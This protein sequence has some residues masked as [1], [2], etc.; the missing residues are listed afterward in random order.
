MKYLVDA[1][2]IVSVNAVSER[3][4]ANVVAIELGDRTQYPITVHTPATGEQSVFVQ[5]ADEDPP[6]PPKKPVAGVSETKQR[7]RA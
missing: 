5:A 6:A 3:D 2:A 1:G 4:A 7:K